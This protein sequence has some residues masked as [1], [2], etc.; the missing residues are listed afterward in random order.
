L[1]KKVAFFVKE[2]FLIE[3]RCVFLENKLRIMTTQWLINEV[4]TITEKNIQLLNA[5]F[6]KLS[7]AQLNWKPSEEVWSIAEVFA[8]LNEYAVF[9]HNALLTRIK[10]TKFRTPQ[11]EFT[12]SPLGRS[13]W[14]SI[15]LGKEKNTKRKFSAPKLYDPSRT[16]SLLTGNEFAEFCSK[17]QEFLSIIEQSL[18]INMRKVKVPIALSKLIR[19]RLGDVLLFVAYHNE[20]HMQ[21][22]INISKMSKFPKK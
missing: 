5:K 7:E 20:R 10:L 2:L 22:A 11:L 6:S 12:S 1:F 8:H 21:Q 14:V 13:S 9:Y 18:Q 3:L 15:K 19:F 4:A 16:K 17:Q